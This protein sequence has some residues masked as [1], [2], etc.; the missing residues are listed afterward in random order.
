MSTKPEKAIYAHL[1]LWCFF[2]KKTIP[3]ASLLG[4]MHLPDLVAVSLF[5]FLEIVS[6][7]TIIVA[8]LVRRKQW[9]PNR[10]TMLYLL[11]FLVA[12]S[13]IITV[14]FVGVPPDFPNIEG[15]NIYTFLHMSPLFFGLVIWSGC[16]AF[17]KNKKQVETI[18]LIFMLM[19]IALIL[20][21]IIFKYLKLFPAIRYW[22]FH[23]RGNYDSLLFY[24][25]TVTGMFS[26][27]SICSAMYFAFS[28]KNYVIVA[29]AV[30]LFL[31]IAA[32]YQ[33][34][35]MV[36]GIA[37]VICFL[38]M[39]VKPGRRIA[40][41]FV[42]AVLICCFVLF[43]Y[44]K[45]F[46]TTLDTVLSGD[47]RS[48]SGGYFTSDSLFSRLGIWS[49]ALDIF[50]FSFPLGAGPGMVPYYMSYSV[51]KYTP[52]YISPYRTEYSAPASVV[53]YNQVVSGKR[54]TGAHNL[55]ISF[56]AE[57]GF[58]GIVALSFFMIVVLH[59]FIQF[60]ER[61]NGYPQVF[62]N[63]FL[64]QICVYSSLLGLGIYNLLYHQFQFYF[65]Y[66]LFFYLTSLLPRLESDRID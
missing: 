33:K 1:I 47:V 9:L 2:P 57:Y 11:F 7:I 18:F 41:L 34:G 21:L 32:T 45:I 44:G 38:W 20:E 24:D 15:K 66:F 65:L 26:I 12:L 36:G 54:V 58:L 60:R 22:V 25:Y 43:G 16:A 14:F 63:N 31:P 64:P 39:V 52:V 59:T 56:I 50:I 5:S 13:S 62:K 35:P 40:Y 53:Y 8:L 48:S 23:P 61:M 46:L 49:R 37:A 27:I 4:R 51:Q 10:S 30:L 19:G 6:I 3:T 29:L 42:I 17:I 28:R 55:Y